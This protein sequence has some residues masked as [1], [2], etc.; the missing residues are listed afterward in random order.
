MYFWKIRKMIRTGRR[1]SVPMAKIA[2]QSV[3]Y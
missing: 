3:D 2:D 1:L